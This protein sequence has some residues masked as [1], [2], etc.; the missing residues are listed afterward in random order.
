MEI[1][2]SKRANYTFYNIRNYL[3]HFWSPTVAQKFIEDVLH[4]TAL[5]EKNPMLGKYNSELICRE[6]LISKHINLY[7]RTK[8]NQIEL[9]TFFN[10][11]QKPIKTFI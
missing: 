9:I 4:I 7:Y 1:I 3:E 2:W 11:R 6:I 8:K 5:L 10:N